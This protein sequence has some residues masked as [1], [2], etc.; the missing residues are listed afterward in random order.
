MPSS[1]LI[2]AICA[3]RWFTLVEPVVQRFLDGV[4]AHGVE[5]EHFTYRVQLRVEAGEPRIEILRQLRHIS[6]PSMSPGTILMV[7]ATIEVS[8]RQ[9]SGGSPP[10]AGQQSQ[11]S[12]A[13]S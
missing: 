12:S 1:T 9:A 10:R 2:S 8:A 3:E 13:W 11:S 4:K 5:H 7:V 6:A